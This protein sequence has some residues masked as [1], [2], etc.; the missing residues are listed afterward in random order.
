MVFDPCAVRCA[1]IK[2]RQVDFPADFPDFPVFPD[3]PDIPD[4]PDNPRFPDFPPQLP[5][6]PNFP[7]LPP[8][9]DCGGKFNNKQKQLLTSV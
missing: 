1:A 9:C 5:E 3:L 4:L 6:L 2:K 8:D 7:D